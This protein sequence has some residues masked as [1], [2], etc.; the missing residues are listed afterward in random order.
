MMRKGN[1][2]LVM[3]FFFIQSLHS[4]DFKWKSALDTI[5][6]SG[7]YAIPLGL[8]WLDRLKPDVSDI[9]IKNQMN[10]VVPY[11]KQEF[12]SRALSGY[13]IH[14][15]TKARVVES[16]DGKTQVW[17]TNELAYPI[18]RLSM[19]VSGPRFFKRNVKVYK[20]EEA[21]MVELL[22]YG[23]LISTKDP[24]IWLRG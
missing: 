2:I 8:D 6:Q 13:Y 4:Q 21:E 15:K 12:S 20:L 23:E 16:V 1:I 9:R 24:V 18:D 7:F 17:I 3:L 11:I 10:E 19:K 5:R 22:G 14:P